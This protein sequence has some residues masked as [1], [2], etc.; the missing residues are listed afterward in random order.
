MTCLL[1]CKAQKNG[2]SPVGEHI[3][4]LTLVDQDDFI[5]IDSF[6]TRVIRDTKS[7]N[8]FYKEINKT[9]KP[10]LPTPMVDFS[11]DMLVLVCLGEQKGKKNPVLS[12]LKE[13]DEEISVAVEIVGNDENEEI[14]DSPTYFP[15]YL[16]KMP[17]VDKTV[18]FQKIEE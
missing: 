16:Y 2:H 12:K 5:N 9:R 10:G 14:K 17:L 15:F 18:V 13:T 6:E 4:D 11:R 8:K 3:D 7:L 1:S